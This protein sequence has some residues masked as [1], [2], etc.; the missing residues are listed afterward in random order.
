MEDA[1]IKKSAQNLKA[2]LKNVNITAITDR[3]IDV[4]RGVTKH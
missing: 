3:A 2:Y 4:S 1:H